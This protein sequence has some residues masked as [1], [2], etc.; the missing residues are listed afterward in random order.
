MVPS[1]H[2]WHFPE[3][4]TFQIKGV[5]TLK[6][7]SRDSN[8][9]KFVREICQ[10]SCDARNGN[11]KV[12][13]VFDRFLIDRKKF[14][15]IHGFEKT[16]D[17]CIKAGYGA[18]ADRTAVNVFKEM[19][20]KLSKGRIPVLRVSD[21]GTKGACG[22][23]NIDPKS[24]T[25]W[26]SMTIGK[27]ISDKGKG[28]GGSFGRGKESFFSVSDFHTV[29]FSTRD[30]EGHCASIGCS[31]LMT[32]Y[33]ENNKK[34]DGFGICGDKDRANNYSLPTLFT[35]GSFE[36]SYYESGTDI[37]VLGY[38][39]EDE[40]WSDMIMINVIKNFFIKIA[41]DELEVI[42]GDKKLDSLTIRRIAEGFKDKYSQEADSLDLIIEQLDLYRNS[43][44]VFYDENIDLFISKSEKHS[45]ISSIRS[46]MVIERSYMSSSNIIGLLIVHNNDVSKLLCKC[47]PTTHDKW[48]KKG[49]SNATPSESKDIKRLLASFMDIT[50]DQINQIRGVVKDE[51]L[52]AEGIEKYLSYTTETPD[53][54]AISRKEY[55]WSP[56]SKIKPKKRKKR[57][58]IINEIPENRGQEKMNA[59]DAD[60]REGGEETGRLLQTEDKGG[61]G[62]NP[63]QRDPEGSMKRV[64]KTNPQVVM[65]DVV[66]FCGRTQDNQ[67]TCN[68]MFSINKES[69]YY[70]ALNALMSDDHIADRI[71][72]KAAYDAN[73]KSI[74]VIDTY[75][76]GPII[77]KRGQINVLK[78]VLDYPTICNVS[79]EVL[80]YEY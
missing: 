63:F 67:I 68:L 9:G 14:P 73:G 60:E 38:R 64:F 49:I 52:D 30:I 23:A 20:E 10:N 51:M 4:S 8:S 33:D 56:V 70:V 76:A 48:N 50:K 75:H 45:N 19:K 32:H 39:D 6:F 31:E 69:E 65:G 62:P 12:R 53:Q 27:G 25:P 66:P 72:I 3:D 22:S 17:R 40:C 1:Q 41:N 26:T 55:S 54:I 57:P 59:S 2:L 74:P 77:S 16:I 46:G 24:Y 43:D 34:R 18:N 61:D 11:E 71:P 36:R 37:F 15:D 29:F 58:E 80:T 47:E 79:P 44:P 21:Y 35:L 28:S 5:N 13:I 78:F 7:D 42:I